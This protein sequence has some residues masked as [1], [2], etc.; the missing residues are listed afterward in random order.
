[1][2]GSVGLLFRHR[3]RFV[4]S[5]EAG[6]RGSG[7]GDGCLWAAIPAA[8]ALGMIKAIILQRCLSPSS[9]KEEAGEKMVHMQQDS[10]H[11]AGRSLGS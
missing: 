9:K 8:F 10:E 3:E 11:R 1:M 4:S 6:H 5:L 2:D 7:E